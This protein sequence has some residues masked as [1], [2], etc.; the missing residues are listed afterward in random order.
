MHFIKTRL[1]VSIMPPYVPRHRE[2]VYA[3]GIAEILGGLGLMTRWRRAAGWWLQATLVAVLP[4]N[5]HMALHPER[6][7][8]AGRA[9]CAVRP[10]AVPGRLHGLGAVG[11]AA[12]GRADA[13]PRTVVDQ[14]PAGDD[15]AD[16]QGPGVSIGRDLLRRPHPGRVELSGQPLVPVLVDDG[17]VVADS[18]AIVAHL[19]ER[20]PRP[21]AVPG[22]PRPPRRTRAVRRLV[23]PGVEARAQR[24]RRRDRRRGDPPAPARSSARRSTA[25]S[26][27]SRRCSPTG[28]PVR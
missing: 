6:V 24:D 23:Q 3:S 28:L 11:R 5:L 4:A 8:G 14:R 17:D 15:G 7:P 9:G 20:H 2:M 1:Y 22:R 27:S 19:E 26:T 18:M 16:P 10:A 21:A 13:L 25:G 12:L